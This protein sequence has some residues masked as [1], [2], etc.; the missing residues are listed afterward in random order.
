MVKESL[1][2]KGIVYV[3]LKS[4]KVCYSPGDIVRIECRM[5]NNSKRILQ[6]LGL[7]FS[8]E[9]SLGD[10]LYKD[11]VKIAHLGAK[12]C[13]HKVFEWA[14]PECLMR[15]V[16]AR[17]KVYEN[18]H[19]LAGS[20]LIFDVI[21]DYSLAPRYGFFATFAADEDVEFRVGRLARFHINYVQFYDWFE[22]HGNYTP[23]PGDYTILG[24]PIHLDTV[25]QKIKLSK[26]KG[27]KCMAYVPIYAID[28]RIYSRHPEWVLRDNNGKPIKFENWLY[29]V[30]PSRECR[31]HDFLLKG[32]ED[33]IK[34]FK[35]DG[36]HLDQYGEKW[37]SNAYWKS[38][39]VDIT[40]GF[41]ELINDVRDQLKIDIVFNLV[42]AWPLELISKKANVSFIYIELWRHE[43]YSDVQRL[44]MKARKISNK[45]VVI[46]AYMEPHEPSVLLLDAE[47]FANQ[48][49]RIEIGEGN[50]YL[51]DAYFPNCKDIPKSLEIKL[52]NYY[53]VI[54]RYEEYIYHP[55]VKRI[56]NANFKI[57][58]I[59]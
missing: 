57:I 20:T 48:G 59:K 3:E 43:T 13:F 29:L 25:R 36:I 30:N 34:T 19:Y 49:F 15:G 12:K 46:V 18:E 52:Q 45:P 21:R 17:V 38:R 32:L 51:V 44:I 54:T 41:I 2:D 50:K 24:K 8:I 14:A 16:V 39:K 9:G 10:I 7:I 31:F 23:G 28:E 53:D 35:W 26:E 33:S 1:L 55:D 4:H 47:V 42:D 56:K 37:T 40:E 11:E 27:I 58:D 22:Y 5:V 6:H